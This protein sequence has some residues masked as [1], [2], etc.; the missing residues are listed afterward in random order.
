MLYY[1]DLN[2]LLPERL[3]CVTSLAVVAAHIVHLMR[4]S[5]GTHVRR[6]HPLV[7]VR[8]LLDDDLLVGAL[9]RAAARADEPEEAATDGEGDTDP[10]DGEHLGRPR[11]LDVVGVE[12]GAEDGDEGTVERGRS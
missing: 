4:V 1:S 6:S 3:V 7:G 12:N 8:R 5:A 11:S 2:M 10:E 9:A